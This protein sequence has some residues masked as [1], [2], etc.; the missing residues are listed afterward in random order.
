MDARD[1]YLACQALEREGKIRS[2]VG[3][4]GEKTLHNV[5]KRAVEPDTS[6]H[7]IPVGRYVADVRNTHGFFEIQT[8]SLYKLKE[9]A[10]FFLEQGPLTV[11]YPV[12]RENWLLYLD[13]Q[14][15]ALSERRKSPKRGCLTMVLPELYPLRE[16]LFRPGFAVE[17]VLLDGEE[18]RLLDGEGPDKKHHATRYERIPTSFVKSVRLERPEDYFRLLPAELPREAMDSK[19]L[20]RLLHLR[21]ALGA[22]ASLTLRRAGVLE[23][24]GKRGRCNL[25]R[26]AVPEFDKE[27]KEVQPCIL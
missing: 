15:G 21:Q 19:T 22:A 25:Y 12:F 11:V 2:G 7:E 26:F 20:S 23:S 16:F 3:T 27:N 6:C 14:S 1:F 13:P 5:L 4:L 17:A 10:A 24:A 18:I 8:R 9:K